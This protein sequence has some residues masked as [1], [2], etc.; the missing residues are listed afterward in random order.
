M[1]AAMVLICGRGALGFEGGRGTLSRNEA[2]EMLRAGI[3]RPSGL[4]RGWWR[5]HWELFLR[6]GGVR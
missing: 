4:G 5:G 1:N 6:R 3:W 2:G